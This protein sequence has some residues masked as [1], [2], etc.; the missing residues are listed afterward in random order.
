MNN[1][2]V[3]TKFLISKIIEKKMDIVLNLVFCYGSIFFKNCS[4][5]AINSCFYVE[6]CYSVDVKNGTSGTLYI[7]QAFSL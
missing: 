5:N 2:L 1:T 4:E 6:P 7:I 3:N